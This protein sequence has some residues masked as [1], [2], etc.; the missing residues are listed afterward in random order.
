[1]T[2]MIKTKHKSIINIIILAVILS[3]SVNCVYYNTFY[4]ARKEFNAAEKAL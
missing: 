3:V 2:K 1:M 4:H